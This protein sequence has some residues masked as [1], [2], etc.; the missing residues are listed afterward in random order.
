M[1]GQILRFDDF[2]H[3]ATDALL[4]WF[5][6]GTL[7]E[8]EQASVSRHLKD[9]ARCRREVEALNQ[10]QAFCRGD[11]CGIAP[12]GSDEQFKEQLGASPRRDTTGHRLGR[13][14]EHWRRAPHWTRWVIAAQ[15]A[16]VI[17]L[18]VVTSARLNESAAAYHTL[19]ASSRTTTS[20][21]IAVIFTADVPEA[22]LR[23]VVQA[24]GARIIDGPT[25]SDAYVLQVPIGRQAEALA[26]LR[27][28]PAVVLAE[29][30]SAL[31]GR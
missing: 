7:T 29:P 17:M 9:C 3:R 24:A 21:S 2:E 25:S 11:R 13:F 19:G 14:L 4:P 6:N 20:T 27:A 1:S 26:S 10:L 30:L 15:F 28:E 22:A 12:M 8:E 31:T 18:T 5:V 16:A 23:R